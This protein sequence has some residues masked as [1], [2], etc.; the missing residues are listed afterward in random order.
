MRFLLFTL[1]F[2]TL[3][4]SQKPVSLQTPFEKGNGNQSTTYDECIRYYQ[5]LDA[6]YSTI[7]MIEKGKT[8]SGKPLHIVI[9]SEN[10]NFDVNQNKAIVLV[11]NGIHPGEPD[12]IDASMMLMRDLAT[13]KIKVPKN[14][15][16]VVIPVYNIDG[17]LN[18][19]TSSRANQN[20]PEEYGFRGNARNFDLNRDFIKSDT[21][22]SR[23]FQE[24]YRSINPDVFLDNHV[25]NGADYQYTFTCIATQHERLGTTLGNYFINEFYPGI[26]QSMNQKKIDVVPYVNVHS[27]TPD[28]GFEQFTDTP[29]Y[30]TGYTTLFNTLGFVPETHMLK[31]F[32]ER[33]KV[34]YEFMV[35][36]INYTD[37]NWQKIKDI[38]SESYNEYKA[39][40][41]YPI[42]WTID[43]TKVSYIDFKGFEGKNKPSD[44]SGKDRLFYDRSKPFTKKI[45]FYGNYKPSKFVSVPKSYAI[46]QSQWQVIDLLK[47]NKIDYT[48]LK[49]DTIIEVESYKIDSYQ[50]SKSP[51]EGHYGHYNTKVSKKTEKL[52]FVA[53]DYVFST[54]QPAAKYLLET[55]EPEAVDS[56]FN[57]NFFDAILQQ[58]EYFS[59]YVFEDVAKELLDINPIL[60][61]EFDAKKQSDKA[62]S[63]SGSA[64]LDWIYRHSD[65]Y[66]KSHLQYPVYRIVK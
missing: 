55:L 53:G 22:N 9:F 36:V 27:T 57:W 15:M 30:A 43:S 39:G 1:L 66:E 25:S 2:S 17:M 56:Y 62:F 35:S 18:R 58:K 38:R 60:K 11:N 31:S 42:D 4:F 16:V 41:N 45:P 54:K 63:D 49:N 33:V 52:K 5:D 8:D 13:A 64:Q 48:Q 44:I 14:T 28:K 7:Q 12:G 10:K 46:P 26:V 19:N 65:Y 34:T 61:A 3:M 40:T 6:N 47:L 37:A 32:K 51:Y 59:A 20:G 29:R 21:K 23:S 50:T 24:L